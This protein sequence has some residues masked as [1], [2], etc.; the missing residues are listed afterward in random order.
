MRTPAAPA[1]RRLPS[2]RPRSVSEPSSSTKQ[3]TGPEPA[4]AA[5]NGRCDASTAASSRPPP[6][7][8]ADWL[9]TAGHD[10]IDMADRSEPLG[11]PGH[12]KAGLFDMDGVLTDTAK[13]HAAA[14][15]QMFDEF[16]EHRGGNLPPFD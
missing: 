2:Q 15:K 1:A 14:W 10:V 8:K 12:I 3:A 5:A 16:L 7:R 11:L 9:L 13:V 4:S 6:I